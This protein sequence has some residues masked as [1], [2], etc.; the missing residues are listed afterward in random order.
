MVQRVVRQIRE[1]GIDS[2]ITVATSQ[3]QID[4]VSSQL[5]GSVEMVVEPVR[6][7]TFAAISLAAEYLSKEKSVSSDEPVIILPCDAYTESGYFNTLLKMEK[8]VL[9]N[10][11]PLVLMGILP[12][13]ASAKYGYILP[14]TA[15][16]DGS[17][18]VKGFI[19]KPSMELAENLIE[20]GAYWNS[21]VFACR[22]GFLLE[23]A[24]NYIKAD[25]FAAILEH[26]TDFPEISF[27]R[28]VLEKCN[29]MAMV[30]YDEHWHD[31][32]TWLTLTSKLDRQ[33]FGNVTT[34]GTDLSTHIINELDIP[35]M[36]IGTK[37]L[38]IAASP[39]GILVTEKD[40]SE[41]IK[42]Y[43]TSLGSRPMYEERRWGTY[44]VIN[45][46]EFDDGHCALTKQLTLNPEGS[47]SYQSHDC[48]DE[49]WTFVDGEGELVVDDKRRIV[50]RGETVFIA[51]GQKHALKA[52]TK[53][54][55]IE[56]QSG[57]P[58]IETD[59]HRYPLE[60]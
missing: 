60:W 54:T 42:K 8:A 24:D 28:E 25:N 48:R 20:E 41:D 43:A 57:A 2:P 13:Y 45:F 17:W 18:R 3:T 1:A 22:L 14:G 47:I 23:M 27:D 38:L 55:F 31:L 32:G 12:V 49:L 51:R 59:I 44:K 40:R 46:E 11:A 4:S 30:K 9:S 26:Y 52:H 53:L 7:K 21:G 39:D 16:S 50:R 19:E 37:N 36:C 10:I 5:G 56:V 34:D 58:L 29:N 6:R 33:T 15:N 35:L